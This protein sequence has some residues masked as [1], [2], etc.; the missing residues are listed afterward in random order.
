MAPLSGKYDSAARRG[1]P[2]T[3]ADAR[4]AAGAFGF[5]ILIQDSGRQFI[6]ASEM[7]LLSNECFPKDRLIFFDR[8]F[9]ASWTYKRHQPLFASLP[10]QRPAGDCPPAD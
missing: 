4:V 1:D 2:R 9:F 10:L 6:A 7:S 3:S 5:L 8:G